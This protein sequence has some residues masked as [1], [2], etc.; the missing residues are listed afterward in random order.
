VLPTAA[1]GPAGGSRSGAAALLGL[2]LL[3]DV[4]VVVDEAL[5]LRLDDPQRATE[6][7]GRVRQPL[8]AEQQHEDDHEQD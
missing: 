8:R 7:T 3:G 1:S 5:G 6:R 2:R 4:A